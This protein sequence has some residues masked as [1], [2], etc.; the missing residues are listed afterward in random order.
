MD[1]SKYPICSTPPAH[2]PD[3]Y[4][5]VDVCDPGPEPVWQI[6]V[7]VVLIVLVL[8]ALISWPRR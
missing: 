2:T 3:G 1:F 4:I 8:G 6:V 7:T 5:W